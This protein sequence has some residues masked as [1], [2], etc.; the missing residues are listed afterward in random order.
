MAR[1]DYFEPDH[2]DEVFDLL[3]KYGEDARVVAG[4]QSL[5]IL[6]RQG[7]LRPSALISLDR[8]SSLR[9]ISHKGNEIILGAMVTQSELSAE[10]RIRKHLPVLAQAASKVGS[11]HVQNLG[12]VG[13][14]LSHAEPNG[15]SAPALL[16]AG[17]A[18]RAS[19]L[20]GEREIPLESF[21]RGPFENVLEADEALTQIHIPVPPNDARSIY[22]KHVLRAVDR[23]T[24][25]VG[26]M[27]QVDREGRCQTVRI[28]LGGAGPTPVRAKK[29][30][31]L[32]EKEKITD[33]IIE[34]AGM[35]VSRNCD[36]LSDAHGP[37]EYKRKMAGL[38]TK[39]AIR[40]VVEAYSKKREV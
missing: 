7:L 15:D 34:A 8:I 12:T 4:G 21:F 6:I 25:S 1:F 22:L 27:M 3:G 30:E 26:L 33:S 37:A 9:E 39:R 28:G 23:A 2:L 5:L 32:L 14:N 36:P 18:I 40:Q 13:G 38:L 29:A 10:D 19:S 20:R 17:A 16:S 11:V 35:E 31:A 24:V